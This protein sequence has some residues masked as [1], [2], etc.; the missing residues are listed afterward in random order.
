MSDKAN[1][2]KRDGIHFTRDT[3]NA[4]TNFFCQNPSTKMTC[5]EPLVKVTLSIH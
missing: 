4:S 2:D 5:F 3:H 1:L